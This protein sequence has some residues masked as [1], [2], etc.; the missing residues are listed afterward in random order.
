[1]KTQT[2]L[3]LAGVLLA[4]LAATSAAQDARPLDARYTK[5][6][7]QVPMRD[8]KKLFTVVY[9]PR[10]TTRRYAVMMT[11]TPYSV[12][13]YGPAAYPRSLARSPKFADTGFIFV[14]QDVRGRFMSEGDFVHMTPWKGMAGAVATDESTD[15]Y[16]TI[17]WVLSHVATQQRSRRHVGRIVPGLLHGRRAG[18]RAPRAQGGVAAGAPGRLVHGRRRA[19]SRHILA[20]ERVRILRDARPRAAGPDEPS[21][22]VHST[23][24][25]TTATR[26][27]SR[28][29]RCRTPTSCISRAARRSGTT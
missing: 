19:P 26:S 15:A 27:F 11:R 24:A 29:A 3:R 13:P 17:D 18:Q 20:H 14:Y 21:G 10:D 1:M 7:Y 8:G 4:T 25:P 2:V 28:W 12:G 16:D 23:M 22:R 5:T 6:E 9:E